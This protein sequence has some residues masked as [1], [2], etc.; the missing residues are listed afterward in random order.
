[1]TDGDAPRERLLNFPRLICFLALRACS[2]SGAHMF[3]VVL[4]WQVYALTGSALMLGLAGLVRFAP[5]LFL[6]PVAGYAADRFPRRTVLQIAIL[7]HVIALIAMAVNALK[8]QPSVAVVLMLLLP[9]GAARTF[10]NTA[11]RSVLPAL[12]SRAFLP[13]A[14]AMHS[15]VAKTTAV[16]GPVLAGI[17]LT[18][19][20]AAAYATIA[21]LYVMAIVML[22]LLPVVLVAKNRPETLG[23]ALREGLGFLWQKRVLSSSLALDFTTVIAGTLLGLLPV[24]ASDVLEVGPEGLG[25]LRAMPSVGSVLAAFVISHTGLPFRA[26]AAIF[27][28]LFLHAATILVF[29]L[30]GSLALSLV[31]LLIYGGSDMIG[32]ILR[33]S[34]F[35]LSTPNE[36][37]G[38]VSSIDSAIA[39]GSEELGSFRSGLVA[40]AL[41]PKL[42]VLIGGV[43]VAGLAAVWIW[44]SPG[45]RRLG[46][47]SE[48]S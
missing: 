31:A 1:M 35:Q 36:M 27:L 38:R 6:F 34:L 22:A 20:T 40:E 43:M 48:I 32:V 42:A 37:L 44:R 23:Q 18:V 25:L 10:M 15:T 2:Q 5:I 26:G 13:R 8:D 29:A 39:N 14:V 3:N 11:A 46:R 33:Q 4:G 19:S 12:C 30:S 47:L 41:G 16:A 9:I 17:I 28:C 7:V 45:L 21:V 24:F